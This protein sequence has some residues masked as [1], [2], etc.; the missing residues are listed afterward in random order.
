MER[1]RMIDTIRGLSVLMVFLFHIVLIWKN[2]SVMAFHETP[3]FGAFANF[4]LQWGTY[5]VDVF[6]TLSG[7]L[8]AQSLNRKIDLKEFYVKRF[9]RI[10]PIYYA[11]VLG[12]SILFLVAAPIM[13]KDPIQH[14]AWL[15]NQ[16]NQAYYYTFLASYRPHFGPDFAGHLWSLAVEE[17][18]Y[19]TFPLIFVC[20]RRHIVPVCTLIFLGLLLSRGYQHFFASEVAYDF[21]YHRTH[22]RILGLF[23]GALLYFRRELFQQKMF[24]LIFALSALAFYSSFEGLKPG[25][26]YLSASAT[27]AMKTSEWLKHL[28]PSLAVMFVLAHFE[29]FTIRGRLTLP[30][31]KLGKA[32]LSF[33]VFGYIAN[34]LVSFVCVLTQAKDFVIYCTSVTLLTLLLSVSS[35]FVFEK[36]L[37]KIILRAALKQPTALKEGPPET[38]AAKSNSTKKAG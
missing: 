28:M 3:N 10:V 32:S 22:E 5:G 34:C 16:E 25:Q 30:L 6:F 21:H 24:G 31:E 2:M 38:S 27:T 1:N 19:L 35:Y 20:F 13:A 26:S 7:Y 8:I 23:L 12:N 29:S 33:Y 14:Q 15:W 11:V 18:F 9:A 4:C 17:H 36:W 37:F